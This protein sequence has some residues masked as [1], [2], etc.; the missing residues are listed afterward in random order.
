[1][2]RQKSFP[3]VW[4]AHTGF[5]LLTTFLLWNFMKS[6]P[7]EMLEAAKVDGEL[8]ITILLLG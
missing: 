1:M 6:L 7:N 8:H 5:G 4:M 2:L 3:G